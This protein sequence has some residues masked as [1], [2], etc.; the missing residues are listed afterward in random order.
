[1]LEIEIKIKLVSPTETREVLEKLGGR[2]TLNL[3][4][5]DTYYNSPEA[6]GDFA[7][8]DE[9]LRLRQTLEKHAE[10][11]VTQ[12]TNYDITYK[13]PKMDSTVKSRIEHV[14]H[15][16]EPDKIDA[17]LQALHFRKVITLHKNREVY[18]IEFH[19]KIIECLID[20][21]EGLD[22]YYFEAEIMADE[23]KIESM[24]SKKSEKDQENKKNI[25][26][27]NQIILD[28]VGEL[29]Y[30]EKDSILESYLELVLKSK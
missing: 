7:I 19:D 15:I 28:L 2:H 17:I 18:Q 27:A 10:T 23:S 29:G 12:K 6:M 3:E 4:Q 20:Q 14:C 30:S 8:S 11:G 26:Q 1:M 5:I 24:D 21:I 9:A 13:G 25:D 16:M 22:G